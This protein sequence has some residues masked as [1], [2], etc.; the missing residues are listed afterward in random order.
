[1]TSRIAITLCGH[2]RPACEH[3]RAQYAEAIVRAGGEP[4]LLDPGSEPPASFDG[5]LL[6]GGGDVDPARYGAA[7]AGSTEIDAVRDELELALL[8]RALAADL[9]VLGVCRGHQLI[10]VAFGG[11][12]R[13]HRTGHSVRYGAVVPHQVAPQPG[14]LLAAAC[15]TAPHLVNS[16]H[17]QAVTDADTAPGIRAV[18]RVDGLVEALESPTHR[19]VVG[20][21][22]HPERTAEV[23]ARA[24]RIFAAFV[25]ASRPVAA[26]AR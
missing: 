13:Q 21:Q 24:T 2:T 25:A 9:P 20:V 12:L 5:L 22:W 23:D 15:G 3:A 19:F 26:P 14:S 4:V 7:N 17:H 18:A 11:S 16:S 10:N 1:M 6:S 8:G